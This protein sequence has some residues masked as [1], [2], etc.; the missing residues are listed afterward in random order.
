[1]LIYL[2]LF[3]YMAAKIQYL[4]KIKITIVKNSNTYKKLIETYNAFS[5]RQY[6]YTCVVFTNNKIYNVV[7][8][9]SLVSYKV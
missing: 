7:K 5:I 3:F 4:L 1:M 2:S 9:S 6:Q 8:F